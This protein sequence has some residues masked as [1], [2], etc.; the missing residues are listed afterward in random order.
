MPCLNSEPSAELDSLIVPFVERFGNQLDFKTELKPL[1][2]K[3]AACATGEE[4]TRDLLQSLEAIND[5]KTRRQALTQTV[6]VNKNAKHEQ[7]IAILRKMLQEPDELQQGFKLVFYV[8]LRMPKAEKQAVIEL[9]QEFKT[10]SI[11]TNLYAC[12]ALIV[13]GE[14]QGFSELISLIKQNV[15]ADDSAAQTHFSSLFGSI[16]VKQISKKWLAK[17]N[18][19]D[20]ISRFYQQQLFN[21]LYPVLTELAGNSLG[22][23]LMMQSCNLV[24]MTYLQPKL[25]ALVPIALSAISAS[26]NT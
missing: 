18:G 12:K 25:A 17:E 8:L 24:P 19:Y 14:A 11:A 7:T 10:A 26:E 2:N 9:A 5:T 16:F 3:Q 21:K 22:V 1:I 4:S 23:Q 20:A 15:E 13:R 6:K